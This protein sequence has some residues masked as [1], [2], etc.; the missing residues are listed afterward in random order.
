[1][2]DPIATYRLQFHHE[3]TFEAFEKIIPY[4]KKL[5]V[6]T[7]YA[8]PIFAA[9][10]GSM[11][12]YDGIDPNRVNPEIG[13]KEQLLQ[14]YQQ[15]F[16]NELGWL[17]DIVPNHMAFHPE[18]IWLMDVL[19]KGP[20]SLYA[21]FFDEAWTSQLYQGRL[22]VPFL[23]KDLE[24]TIRQ[25]ELKIVYSG[26]RF[27]FDYFGNQYPL[28][29]HT[30]QTILEAHKGRT[31]ESVRQLI[32]QI[33]KSED[34]PTY[35]TQWEEYL[36]QLE[37]LLQ[38]KTVNNFIDK[39]LNQINNDPVYLKKIADEQSYRLC[40]WNETDRQINYRRFFTVN[41]LI[42]M[43]I[44]DENV[45]NTYHQLIQSLVNEGIFQ[46]LRVDHVDGLYD[47]TEYLTR[48]RK[49]T[50]EETYI[51][52][53]KILQAG[54]I[55]PSQWPIEGNTGYDFLYLVNNLL[56]LK[57]SEKKFTDF[58][59]RIAKNNHSLHQQ[60]YDKKY[61]ILYQHMAGELDNLYRLFLELDL[62]EKKI[63][64][65]IRK[66]DLKEAI[67]EFLIQCPVYRYYGSRFPLMDHEASALQDVFNRIRK[68]NPDIQRA[69]GILE[70]S[71][72]KKPSEGNVERNERTARFYQRCMQFTGPLMAKGVEDTLMYTYNRFIAHN[73]VGDSPE[74]FGITIDQFHL[75]MSA[76]QQWWPYSLNTTATHDTKRG[77]DV[78]ARLNV[79]S[80]LPHEW[81]SKASNWIKEDGN[82][83]TNDQ[84]LILQNIIGTFP[85][86]GAEEE[87]YST[88]LQEY[89]QKALRE[90]KVHTNWTT[91]D[92][93][94]ERV[95]KDFAITLIDK[96]KPSRQQIESFI[97]EIIDYGIINSLVQVLLKFT[98]PG[99]P[100]VY[101]GCELWDLS[102]V[103]P[104]NRK[105]VNFNVR[106]EILNELEEQ[107]GED[108][109]EKLWEER[110]N[111]KIKLWLTQI[112]YQL[113]KEHPEVFTEGVYKPLKTD[114][115]YKDHILA[116]ARI[117]KQ[118]IYIVVVPLHPAVICRKQ[119]ITIDKID[120][121]DTRISIPKE[122]EN[123]LDQI[124]FT[125][126]FDERKD[127]K[128]KDIFK[129]SPF[130]ILKGKVGI[131]ERG[132]GILLHIS[133]LPS[134]FGIGDMGPEAKAFADFLHRSHQKYWQLL[135]LNPIEAGQGNSPYSSISS[136]AGNP[137]F[138]SPELLIQDNLLT[139]SDLQNFYLNNEAKVNFKEA[140]R[141]KE[142]L[143]RIAYDRYQHIESSLHDHYKKF[144]EQEADWLDNFSLYITLKKVHEGKPWFQWPDELKLRDPNALEEFSKNNQEAIDKVKWV[145]FIFFRQWR[146]LK[147]YCNKLGIQLIGDLPFY[148]SYDSSDVWSHRELFA[149][150]ELG[151]RTGIGGVPPDA[152]SAEGQLWGMPV[153]RWDKLK[154]QN[155]QWWIKR[156]RANR[157]L[158]DL[159]RIDHFR[160]F[161]EY[162]EV[163]GNE[164][165]AKNGQWIQGP[166]A[167]FFEVVENEL[168]EL[169]FV[170]EDLGE[171]ND[172]V[173]NLRDQFR[174]PGMKVLQFAFAEDMPTSDYIP[175]NYSENFL[176]YT[177]THDNNTI[178]GWFRKD[179]NEET[180]K[181]LE[182]YLGRAIKEEDIHWIMARLAY[183]STARIAILPM[184]DIL[185]LDES[186]R[187]NVP[188]SGSDNW[189]WRLLPGQIN[190]GVEEQ[191]VEWTW[192]YNRG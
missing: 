134:P 146:S 43:N 46:G 8:S 63:F 141:M 132:A 59:R 22:M 111:G 168:K 28:Q 145:Q 121:K 180:R 149:L 137:L 19:E 14:I 85:I 4:L 79:L 51:I 140:E 96:N 102:M 18:N 41:G 94:Y 173:Y 144:T 3:F 152:F 50:G 106:E 147:S 68:S 80:D 192:L 98:C 118:R 31:P 11:H 154:E 93:D 156:I 151:N 97:Q 2:P 131:N 65:S 16:K 133:S 89:I 182:H 17:Q 153:F 88:R 135:P 175:H 37:G 171:V 23:G 129:K 58:Y 56:T 92:E 184:Q 74:S 142:E 113:R 170:A 66:D 161:A 115:S 164:Q 189:A 26:K 128:I 9:T 44:Q 181:R 158:F 130:A 183:S 45:F 5:G 176:V 125:A 72:L 10:P 126:T 116:F 42:C 69:I 167:D 123:Q 67:G 162:W 36:L 47:P 57:S 90:A 40:S 191:L 103:D 165:T 179:I 78:R 54:E 150:D 174:L 104:D 33:P 61:Y 166:G 34:A 21:S 124:F 136:K 13:T 77:E 32:R 108:L 100:D 86:H 1:M 138:I 24:E 186:A 185:G 73:E 139:R 55:L 83:D 117:Y 160:A 81:I 25:G 155:Y 30:Y 107:R 190:Q 91:P 53:E 62:V 76:R 148:V 49:L 38:N 110:K 159:V 112:L 119:N 71:L 70:D 143:L 99:V 82:T 29:P 120:W 6:S 163:P 188:S 15:S 178:R 157:E 52:V 95:A 27:A 48:L 39:C 35:A 109:L 105:P 12:G 187:M 7:I 101:Q 114:G 169:P 87:I 64:S 75:A 20:Q 84:Y 122:V 172:A 127:L 60:L 177:G